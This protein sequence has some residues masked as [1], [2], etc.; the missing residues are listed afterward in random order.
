VEPD[1]ELQATIFDAWER[2]RMDMF[3]DWQEF[4][5]VM[6][7]QATPE[8]IFRRVGEFL[9]D[10]RPPDRENQAIDNAIRSVLEP[11]GERVARIFRA[12]YQPVNNGECNTTIEREDMA[13]MLLNEIDR[14]GLKPSPEPEPL[15]II[16]PDE[17]HLLTWMMI[18]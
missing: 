18:V 11:R 7:L 9:E 8:R 1:T 12:I 3:R 15:S 4:T 10:N 2:A 14:Q 5:D 17:I 6:N 16:D 13:R